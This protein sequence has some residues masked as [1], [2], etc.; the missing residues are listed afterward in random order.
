MQIDQ[1]LFIKL[2]YY[3]HKKKKDTMKGRVQ[4]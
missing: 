3:L 1:S 4:G 2:P